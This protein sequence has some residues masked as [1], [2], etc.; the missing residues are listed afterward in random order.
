MKR[1][2]LVLMIVDA[3]V[4]ISLILLN[5]FYLS[6]K[7]PYSATLYFLFVFLFAFPIIFVKYLENRR[8]K[9]I[10]DNFPV[11][12]RDFVEATRGGMTIPAAFKSVSGNDYGSLTPHIKKMAAQLDWG[13]SVEKVLTKFSKETK[14][15]IISR[16]V[17]TVIET[18]K[19]GGNLAN[20]FEALSS[21]AFE[22]EKLRGERRL[23]INSQMITGYIIFFVFLAVLIGLQKY[24][25]PSLSQMSAGAAALGTAKPP[26]NVSAQYT[27]VFRNLI[28]LQG[29]FA[30]LSIG[31]MAEGAMVSGLKHSMFMMLVG[32]VVFALFT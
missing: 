32:G 19:F 26:E 15:R 20:T 23:Y 10:E 6:K 29:L 17:S 9:A 18:H 2:F 4:V 13:L 21:T 16:I 8:V 27:E 3:L 25:V 22:M 28:L 24:L 7:I 5:F 30:G 12:L 14:S 1:K 31:R 11:F